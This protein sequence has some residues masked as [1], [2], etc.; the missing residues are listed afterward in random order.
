MQ[1]NQKFLFDRDFDLEK[2][3]K[4]QLLEEQQQAA[5]VPPP[6]MFDEDTLTAARK[7]A[8]SQGLA[9]G[10][11][12]A[13]QSQQQIMLGLVDRIGHKLAM[14]LEQEENRTQQAQSMA[15]R[16]TM[17]IVKKFWP[18]MQNLFGQKDIEDFIANSLAENN[19]ETRI[20]LRVNDSELDV[21]AAQLPRLKELQGFQG[22][23]ITLA[24]DSVQ[25]GDCKMEWA[26]GGAEKLGRHTMQQVEQLL[27]RLLKTPATL[28]DN[29]DH[30]NDPHDQQDERG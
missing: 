18:R 28:T 12:Q 8:Y 6:V 23:V 16:A 30:D 10:L 22:K 20:V 14:L 27:D 29:P 3:R 19:D 21:I 15:L 5:L 11:A 26:D 24:D 9:A 4:Q 1:L 13:E 2:A 25:A 17:H 7:E